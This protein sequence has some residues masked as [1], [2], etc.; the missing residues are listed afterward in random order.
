[1]FK[2]KKKQFEMNK[3]RI[4]QHKQ[5]SGTDQQFKINNVQANTISD[6]TQND[7]IT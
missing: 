3:N 6:E 2:L 4:L 5:N 7:F 1:V